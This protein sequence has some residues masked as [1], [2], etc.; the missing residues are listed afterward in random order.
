M[1]LEEP[2]NSISDRNNFS[3]FDQGCVISLEKRINF[4]SFIT[5]NTID[6]F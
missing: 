5:N 1:P 3:F 6:N 4:S 2:F